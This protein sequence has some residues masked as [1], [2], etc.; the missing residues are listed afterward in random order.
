LFTCFQIN[1]ATSHLLT[2][3]TYTPIL[4]TASLLI[5][6]GAPRTNH[7]IR[8]IETVWQHFIGPGGEISISL[9]YFILTPCDWSIQFGGPF[10]W[11]KRQN[12]V[13]LYPYP[14]MHE[15]N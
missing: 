8:G 15:S 5:R 4:N 9:V 12:H 1:I 2:S 6:S 3:S 11:S 13:L 10:H 7:S 14:N